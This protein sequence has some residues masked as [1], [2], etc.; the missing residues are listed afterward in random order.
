MVFD[1]GLFLLNHIT[2]FR[3][4]SLGTILLKKSYH[5]KQQN[6]SSG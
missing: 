2:T 3:P 6:M 1:W 4:L 5:E